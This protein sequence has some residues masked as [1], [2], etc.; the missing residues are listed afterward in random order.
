MTEREKMLAGQL[1][2]A[3]GAE[4]T[5]MRRRARALTRAFNA[6]TEDETEERHRILGE[7]FGRIGEKIEIEPPFRCDY[8]SHIFAGENFYANFGVVML[9]CAA[10]TIGDNVLLAP[11]VQLYT[12]YHPV[13]PTIRASMLEA[14]SP[15][16]IGH[17]VWI[18]GGAIVLPG[19][20]V[21]DNTIVGAGS[22]VIRSLP[23]NVVA[24]GNP[25]RVFRAIDDSSP[26]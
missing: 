4:L 15:T 12:A 26:A 21:G 22:V 17:N 19:V 25:C 16:T 8:G 3:S 7:L 11:N 2:D 10:I 5:E 6:T 20:S 13:D 18:G 23:H 24:A 14:A 9:D 1:Y